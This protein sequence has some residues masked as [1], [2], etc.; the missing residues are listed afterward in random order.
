MVSSEK[1]ETELLREELEHFKME[2]EK[3]RTL[4][5][6]IGGVREN[7]RESIITTVF[8]A[9][10]IVLF[11]LDVLR[12]VLGY[13]VP[14]PDMFSITLGVLLVSI[15][16]IWMIH[17]QNKLEHFQFWI[18]NSIEFRLNDIARKIDSKASPMK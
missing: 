12:H 14:L 11:I 16:I 2:K 17:K 18:L 6:Q 15:K 3:I 1:T 4:V 10:I 5:G 9:A 7:R 13:D 8:I